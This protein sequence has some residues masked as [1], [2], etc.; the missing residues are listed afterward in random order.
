VEVKTPDETPVPVTTLPV[1]EGVAGVLELDRV[2]VAEL[3]REDDGAPEIVELGK[4]PVPLA[5]DVEF[6]VGYG[7][8]LFSLEEMTP[9][10]L[11]DIPVVKDELGDGERPR[12][13]ELEERGEVPVPTIVEELPT[14]YGAVELEE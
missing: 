11:D 14:G 6:P 10:A 1:P 7:A 9:E 12:P 5:S 13:K 4:M 3:I 2:Y 8:E